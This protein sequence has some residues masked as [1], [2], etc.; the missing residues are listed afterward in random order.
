MVV[1]TGYA[2]E[3][4]LISLMLGITMH[5]A[6]R[7]LC[8]E[9]AVSEEVFPGRSLIAGCGQ[10]VDFSR[11]ALYEVLDQA[12]AA[13]R[14]PVLR[15]RSWVDDLAHGEGGRE[16]DVEYKLTEVVK[17]LVELLARRGSRISPKTVA[18][19]TPPQVGRRIGR[20]LAAH[21]I[22]LQYSGVGV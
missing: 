11:L 9:H 12:L 18:M 10:A 20:Q 7:R 16:K 2:T 19:T 17:T 5:M 15:L 8:T 13:Y 1:R 21:G 3:Y 4:P 14:P 22:D 6:P